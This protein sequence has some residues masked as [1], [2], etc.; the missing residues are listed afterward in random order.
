MRQEKIESTGR[1]F[2]D[3]YTDELVRY[4]FTDNGKVQEL[5]LRHQSAHERNKTWPVD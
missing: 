3:N 4:G 2:D 1:L 5:R